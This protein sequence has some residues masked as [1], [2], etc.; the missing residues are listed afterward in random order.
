MDSLFETDFND[1]EN[2]NII[3]TKCSFCSSEIEGMPVHSVGGEELFCD[4]ACAKLFND[5]RKPIEIDKTE[6]DRYYEDGL[7][8][9]S[10]ADLYCLIRYSS[11]KCL[12][13]CINYSFTPQQL[14][15]NYSFV[16]KN[17][18]R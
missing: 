17:T 15:K 14:K 16:I 5:N 8:S 18:V 7:L 11:F 3:N 6:Y 4:I 9:D 2:D 13:R 12:P 1:Y 10:A